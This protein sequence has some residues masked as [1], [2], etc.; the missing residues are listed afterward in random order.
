VCNLKFKKKILIQKIMFY[1][2]FVKMMVK[3]VLTYTFNFNLVHLKFFHLVDDIKGS[4]QEKSILKFFEPNFQFG[5][6]TSYNPA[7]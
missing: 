7:R 5:F 6:Y 2:I 4:F 1:C 3:D